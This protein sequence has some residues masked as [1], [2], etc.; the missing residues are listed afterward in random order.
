M[1]RRIFSFFQRIDKKR[2]AVI[3]TLFI[4]V[5]TF[6]LT[7]LPF[8]L[9]I[10][11][12]P[13]LVIAIYMA[14]YFAILE[15]I[16][17]IELFVLFIHPI[18]FCISF[19][20]F[21]YLL[22]SRLLTKIPFI[23]IFSIIFYSILLAENIFNVGVEKGL[24]LYRAAYSISN[25][26]T[27]IIIFFSFTVLFSFRLHFLINVF[28]TFIISWPIFF[29]TVWSASPKAVLEERVYKYATILSFLLTALV[30]ALSFLPIKPNIL[31]IYLSA[32]AYVLFS[33]TQEVV[34]DTAFKERIQ[35]YIV[36]FVIMTFLILLSLE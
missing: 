34:S 22:P 19:L 33:I 13:I 29:H 25:F 27:L 24:A 35:G 36:L 12:L 23:V 1:N 28:L 10:Y 15:Q 21:F 8:N 18:F 20:L 30:F 14:T 7:L 31:S 17:R 5:L 16:D 32:I 11:Y 6:F 2:R 9:L 26:L 4:G 3:A